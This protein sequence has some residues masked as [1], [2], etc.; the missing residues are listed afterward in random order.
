MK[1]SEAD[2]AGLGCRPGVGNVE[3]LG[4]APSRS[5]SGISKEGGKG[6]KKVGGGEEGGRKVGERKWGG[7]K[8]S[9]EE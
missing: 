8:G 2:R 1:C 3:D 4:L 6:G 5:T 7:R 9:C